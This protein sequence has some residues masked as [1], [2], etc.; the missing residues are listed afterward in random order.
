MGPLVAIDSPS[1]VASASSSS[2]SS[3]EKSRKP[4]TPTT[5]RRTS[6]LSS[7]AVSMSGASDDE[8][9][10]LKAR[11]ARLEAQVAKL[12]SNFDKHASSSKN[13]SVLDNKTAALSLIVFG[14]Y[15][16]SSFNVVA[17]LLGH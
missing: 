7:N 13:V 1:V 4:A 5:S 16:V 11:V 6:G 17:L 12:S 8:V 3:L 2:G 10:A 14:L 9:S 15:L